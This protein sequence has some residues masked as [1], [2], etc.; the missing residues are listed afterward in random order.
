MGARRRSMV[1]AAAGCFQIAHHGIQIERGRLLPRR[2]LHEVLDLAGHHGLH[3]VDDVRMGEHPVPIGVRVLVG[4]LERISPQVEQLRRPQLDERLEP[5]LQ[6]LRTYFPLPCFSLTI[7]LFF[8]ALSHKST[9]LSSKFLF[10]KWNIPKEI[11][12]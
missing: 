12:V 10:L 4:P 2:E 5:A 6:R 8:Q 11:V 1:A 9:Y 3:H 7:A